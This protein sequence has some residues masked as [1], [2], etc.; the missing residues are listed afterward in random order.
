MPDFPLKK[1]MYMRA[2]RAA[3]SAWLT[4]IPFAGWLI[5]CFRPRMLVELGT[6]HGSSYLA[7]CQAIVANDVA[8]K[9]F[10]V[11]TWAGDE[12][13]GE[14]GEEVY[15]QLDA[16]HSRKYAGFSELMR[17]TFDEAADYFEDGSVDLLHID[18]LHT[19]DAVKHDF[20]TWLPKL[21]DRAIV[22]FHDTCVRERGFGV[23]RFWQEIE[24]RYDCFEFTHGHGLG[25]VSVGSV[26]PPE[27]APLFSK[28]LDAGLIKGLFERLGSCVEDDTER[29]R[30]NSALVH[31][32]SLNRESKSQDKAE[33]TG[34]F[35][36]V[37]HDV[38]HVRNLIEAEL[39]KLRSA[40]EEIRKMA[41]S[42]SAT[43]VNAAGGV[44]NVR[45]EVAQSAEQFKSMLSEYT[46]VVRH[47]LV[48]VREQLMSESASALSGVHQRLKEHRDVLGE[49]DNRIKVLQE[50]E[51][52]TVRKVGT[53]ELQLGELGEELGELSHGLGELS[54]E[55]EKREQR[56][57]S[58]KLLK[59]LGRDPSS[60]RGH[61]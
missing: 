50:L 17:M 2:E 13:A 59:L 3:P 24:Q 1:S 44:E 58:R 21:S 42:T 57:W 27:I 36:N 18:G 6:H 10:A 19:Y 56:K 47:D 26:V 60:V 40:V 39:A 31:E 41:D 5:E 37:R 20:E 54:E 51:D 53:V 14:Y 30:L 4:H 12:H 52:Q 43:V 48:T 38:A 33:I 22:L 15:E 28:E 29:A 9:C 8:C 23:W 46:D 7:F 35:E 11:D 61:T 49:M 55:L 45:S 25:V 34:G 16:Y 32:R